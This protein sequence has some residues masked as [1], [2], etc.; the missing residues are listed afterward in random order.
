MFWQELKEWEH[1]KIVDSEF[2]QIQQK[3]DIENQKQ[4]RRKRWADASSLIKR[5]RWDDE[6]R[7]TQPGIF[8]FLSIYFAG[9]SLAISS[10]LISLE[11]VQEIILRVRIRDLTHRID[12]VEKEA[13]LQSNDPRRSP[14]PPPVYDS[15]GNRT[16]TRA[17]RLRRCLSDLRSE[18]IEEL[19]ILN[20]ALRVCYSLLSLF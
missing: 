9:L 8:Y 17:I 14:S 16:N 13:E 7:F 11:Q 10:E 3:E 4:R 18:L 6:R 5:S 2:S 1:W 15:M 19:L 12:N 20:P